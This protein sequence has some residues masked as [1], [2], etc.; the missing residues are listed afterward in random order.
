MKSVCSSATK[1]RLS[2]NNAI[3]IFCLSHAY[4]FPALQDDAFNYISENATKCIESLDFLNLDITL[5][6]SLVSSTGIKVTE[7]V[8]LQRVL[9]WSLEECKRKGIPDS[10]ENLRTVLGTIL[11]KIRY[12][13]IP[14]KAFEENSLAHQVLNEEEMKELHR[15]Y[16][17]SKDNQQL[18]SDTFPTIPRNDRQYF[19]VFRVDTNDYVSSSSCQQIPRNALCV[20]VSGPLWLFWG[21]PFRL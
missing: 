11:T 7:S 10:F 1:G 3:A 6:D 2:V 14:D 15:L 8:L 12:M 17:Y 4:H 9:D 19:V 16:D 20:E 21:L 5:L 13:S 18:V